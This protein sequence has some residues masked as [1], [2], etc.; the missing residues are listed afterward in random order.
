MHF[1]VS[2]DIKGK[3][4]R[5]TE[6]N[7]VMKEGLNGY[8]WVRPL[9]TFYI[10]KVNSQYDWNSVHENLLTVAKRYPNEVNFVMSPLMDGGGYNGWLPKY[11]WPNIRERAG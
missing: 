4:Q 2:W 9:T 5:W 7:D 6:I 1:V 11:L 10:V 3:G 8:A